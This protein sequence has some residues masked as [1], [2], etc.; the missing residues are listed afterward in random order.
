VSAADIAKAMREE[1]QAIEAT[2]AFPDGHWR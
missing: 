1:Q 2:V